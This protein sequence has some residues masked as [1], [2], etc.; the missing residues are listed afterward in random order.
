MVFHHRAG[1]P[2]VEP[3]WSLC[4]E[5]F[6]YVV[7]LLMV[8][9][10]PRERVAIAMAA[11][12]VTSIL[13]RVAVAV[14]GG[15]SIEANIEAYMLPVCRMDAFMLGAI[16]ASL[17]ERD[18]LAWVSIRALDVSIA[19]FAVV[20]VLMTYEDVNL[21]GRF[22]VIIGYAYYAVFFGAVVARVAKGGTFG[23]LERGPL[24]YLGTVS[25]FIYLAHLPII[26]AMSFVPVG[27]LMNLI[28]TSG[29]VI[30]A[31]AISWRWFEKPLIDRGKA[32][33]AASIPR[34]A[35]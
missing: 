2:F 31:A 28:L 23:F 34:R 24:A 16:I 17:H 26:Y 19:L 20:F 18:R 13:L 33:N 5:V 35:S 15:D 25:Y 8:C 27:A 10:I 32:L 7:L 22:A 3:T 1:A 14:T 9:I 12:A 21:F 29:I 4:A 6:L 11:A 30:G